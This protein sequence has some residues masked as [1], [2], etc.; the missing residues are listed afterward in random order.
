MERLQSQSFTSREK[1][2]SV[3]QFRA[4]PYS[5]RGG[6]RVAAIGTS[7]VRTKANGQRQGQGSV[8]YKLQHLSSQ[9]PSHRGAAVAAVVASLQSPV[10]VL[11]LH[12]RAPT[13][14]HGLRTA[15]HSQRRQTTAGSISA[16]PVIILE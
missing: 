12:D 13:S 11:R 6:L 16:G 4:Y 5:S 3:A 7:Q 8:S 14:D 1:Q 15:S 2:G 10:V 9:Q